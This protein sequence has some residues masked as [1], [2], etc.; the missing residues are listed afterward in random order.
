MTARFSKAARVTSAMTP[1]DHG[2]VGAVEQ[3][4]GRVG[5]GVSVGARR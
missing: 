2:Q 4:D 3:P 5:G 1:I